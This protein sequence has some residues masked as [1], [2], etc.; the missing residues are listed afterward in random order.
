MDAAVSRTLGRF[1]A[2]LNLS[3]QTAQELVGRFGDAASVNDLPE[4]VRETDDESG[5]TAIRSSADWEPHRYTHGWHLIG[6]RPAL[7]DAKNLDEIATT[8]ESELERITGRTDIPVH[9][10]GLHPAVAREYAE[11]LLRAQEAFP[12]DHLRSVM[13][14]GPGSSG[15]VPADRFDPNWFALAGLG[16]DHGHLMLGTHRAEPELRADMA[17]NLAEHYSVAGDPTGTAIHEFGHFLADD[18]QT[19]HDINQVV[20]DHAMS[21]AEDAVP[22]AMRH[23]SVNAGATLDEL[24]AEAFADV[25]LNGT[26]AN[27]LSHAIVDAI[28]ANY[29]RVNP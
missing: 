21:D 11:G 1:I 16:A 19:L 5:P 26:A 12:K 18:P 17:R 9:F 15:R 2:S 20:T 10:D 14:V 13:T 4:W 29:E 25:M 8:T 28:R 3:R 27:P 24:G 22:Y 6:V 7:A 23:I